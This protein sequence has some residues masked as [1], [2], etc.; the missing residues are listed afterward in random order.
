MATRFWLQVD[1]DSDLRA[2][3]QAN[4]GVLTA[5]CYVDSQAQDSSHV[6][7]SGWRRRIGVAGSESGWGCIGTSIQIGT[8][9]TH[10]CWQSGKRCAHHSTVGPCS[11]ETQT[12][13]QRCIPASPLACRRVTII[14]TIMIATVTAEPHS[15]LRRAPAVSNTAFQRALPDSSNNPTPTPGLPQYIP[16]PPPGKRSARPSLAHSAASCAGEEE[17]E[18]GHWAAWDRQTRCQDRAWHTTR[19]GGERRVPE[20]GTRP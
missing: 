13:S 7:H 17:G 2:P 10:S 15:P 16:D 11:V 8:Q 5:G 1:S 3:P 18:G 4:F 12:D 20:R 19:R 14:A 6:R 9:T